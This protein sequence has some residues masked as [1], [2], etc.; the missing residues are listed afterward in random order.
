[1]TSKATIRAAT[2]RARTTTATA[3]G[4]A[5]V[6][7]CLAVAALAVPVGASAS[8]ATLK[9][10]LGK[11]S[12]RI[13]MDAHGIGLSA[14]RR[15]PRRMTRRARHFRADAL[16]ARNA[17]AVVRPSSARG[18]RAKSLALA[19]FHD[20][21]VVGSE[22]VLSGQARLSGH[23]AAAVRHANVATRYAR[24]GSRLL[25]AAGRLLR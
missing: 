19:A 8:D 24:V 23:K 7:S 3:S 22:W 14:S 10:T 18:R 21:A 15:H 12:D 9:T 5:F 20:F 13:A 16:R 6:L 2:I 17:V 1:M 11:W 25:L 4:R